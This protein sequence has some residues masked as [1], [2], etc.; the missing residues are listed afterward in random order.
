M[1]FF[2]PGLTCAIVVVLVA[3]QGATGLVVGLPVLVPFVVLGVRCAV[4]A[5][6]QGVTITNFTTKY[7]RWDDVERVHVSRQPNG[8]YIE[9]R[10][11]DGRALK[12]LGTATYSGTEADRMRAQIVGVG[13][14]RLRAPD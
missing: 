1:R 8:Y 5:D 2:I 10:V 14:E 13:P 11:Q 3:A 7:L 6:A 4:G 9:F 12:A